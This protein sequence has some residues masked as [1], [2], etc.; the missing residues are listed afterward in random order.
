MISKMRDSSLTSPQVRQVALNFQPHASQIKA[1]SLA[2]RFTLNMAG[3]GWGKTKWKL[4]RVLK[5]LAKPNTLGWYVAPQK[6]QAKDIA[7]I[8]LLEILPQEIIAR[9]SDSNLEVEL[10]NGSLILFKG[11]SDPD[12]RRG[13]RPKIVAGDECQEWDAD[14][15]DMVL[16]PLLVSPGDPSE[17]ILSGTKKIGSWFWKE[18]HRADKGLIPETAALNFPSMANPLVPASEW[19][20]IRRGLEEKGRRHIWLQEYLCDPFDGDETSSEIRYSEF[21]RVKHLKTPFKIP[22]DWKRFRFIDWGMSHPTICLWAA[23]GPDYILYIY[24]EIKIQGRSV[25]AVAEMINKRNV[26][27]AIEFSVLDPSCWRKESDGVSIA[28]R[29]NRC[30]IKIIPGKREDK[31][32]SGASLVKSYLAPVS[33]PPRVQIFSHC[34][35]LIDELETLRWDAKTGDD[36]SDALRYGVGVVNSIITGRLPSRSD[37]VLNGRV[38]EG[39][40]VVFYEKGNIVRIE[41]KKR[42]G[43]RQG[44]S[45]DDLGSPV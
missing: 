18:W 16:R 8:P 20:N 14:T 30:G 45:Y 19:E 34:F 4:Y 44:L 25:D 6:N 11:I 1:D 36:A 12:F 31:N 37:H 10:T 38:D 27:D 9:K 3:R 39:D 40:Q 5:R 33:G 2:K 29:F 26:G 42:S 7:W 24:D 17:A 35:I 32:F 23:L 28:D 22:A 41:P 15:W 21:S 13:A 43:L